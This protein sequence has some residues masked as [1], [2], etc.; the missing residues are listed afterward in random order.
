M[1]AE[2]SMPAPASRT[3][4]KAICV[5]ANTRRRRFVPGVMRTCRSPSPEP[6][7]GVRPRQARDEG[8]RDGSDHRQAGADPQQRGVHAHVERADGE[9][10][11]ISADHAHHWPREQYAEDRA[12]AAEHHAFRQQ[13]STQRARAG[14]ERGAHSQLALAPNRAREDQIGDVRAR[15]HEHERRG[16]EQD[17]QYRASGRAI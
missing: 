16:R 6:R 15:D 5:T 10:R 4:D 9:A 2:S 8:E 1:S 12:G 11:R 7:W 17:Q 3:N 14:T 13:R